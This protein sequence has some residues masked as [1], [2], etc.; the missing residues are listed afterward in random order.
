MILRAELFQNVD[1]RPAV[2]E[3][4]AKAKATVEALQA[5]GSE[6]VRALVGPLKSELADYNTNFETHP[7]PAA[8]SPRSLR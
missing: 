4:L 2:V 1:G 7:Q 6:N 8:Q 3:A 5:G